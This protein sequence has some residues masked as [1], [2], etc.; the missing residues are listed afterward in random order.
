MARPP[1]AQGR[2]G[3]SKQTCQYWWIVKRVWP[4]PYL[5]FPLPL[6]LPL[7][8]SLPFPVLSSPT[9]P[10]PFPLLSTLTLTLAH[11]YDK[12]RYL[13]RS[14]ARTENS[15]CA[16]SMTLWSCVCNVTWPVFWFL[17]WM[18]H[19]NEQLC[20][21]SSQKNFV[22]RWMLTSEACLLLLF[23]RESNRFS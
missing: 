6:L 17:C 8:L 15:V 23:L 12:W 14:C 20:S 7:S 16:S 3:S 18:Y 4:I 1:M 19:T 13:C 5:S 21:A 22:P 10:H 11:I 9:F 2:H